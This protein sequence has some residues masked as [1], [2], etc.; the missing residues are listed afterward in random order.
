[1]F[2]KTLASVAAV[3][4]LAASASADYSIVEPVEGTKWVA[5]ETVTIRWVEVAGTPTPEKLSLALMVGEPTQLQVSQVIADVDSKAGSY[6]WTV[7]STVQPSAQYAVRAGSGDAVKYSHYFDVEGDNVSVAAV[8][9][10]TDSAVESSTPSSTAA[11]PVASSNATSVASSAT[12]ASN[13]TTIASTSLV[14][15]TSSIASSITSSG[16]SSKPTSAATSAPSKV[17]SQATPS[18]SKT[19][20]SAGSNLAISAIS[21]LI[22][23]ALVAYMRQ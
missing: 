3:A 16:A 13:S 10:S 19:P 8:Q 4:L 2:S 1:M 9:S 18:P 17:S 11:I 22:P 14:S 12:P 23:A 5:G 6:K 20:A 15:P 7:P 21:A